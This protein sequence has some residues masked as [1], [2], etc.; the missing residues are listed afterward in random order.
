[1]G[2]VHYVS[3]ILRLEVSFMIDQKYQKLLDTLHICMTKC[4][5]C[6][7]ACLK[8]ENVDMMTKCIQLDR[9]CAEICSYLQGA[10]TRNSPFI[11]QLATICAEIC[12]TCGE[13]CNRHHHDHCQRCADACF[14]CAKACREVS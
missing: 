3:T 6:F 13:E 4:N 10:I 2:I 9:E 12:Q 1:M 11:K 14:Q 8:E 7:N 5:H